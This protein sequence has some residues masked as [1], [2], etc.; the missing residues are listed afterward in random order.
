VYIKQQFT[1]SAHRMKNSGEQVS[2][3]IPPLAPGECEDFVNWLLADIAY[4]QPQ[5]KRGECIFRGKHIQRQGDLHLRGSDQTERIFTAATVMIASGRSQKEACVL[6]A[7]NPNLRLGLSR[8][9]RPA[10]KPE[11]RDLM[12]KAQTVRAILN[13][14]Q[15]HGPPGRMSELVWQFRW[16]RE[17]GIVEG[18]RYVPDSGRRMEEAWRRAMQRRGISPDQL[19]L[20]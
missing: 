19:L 4:R 20:G 18:S 5:D 16:L 17:N 8:R 2:G 11:P 1:F 6:I 15:F 13:T 9:G 14:F 10:K 3:G 7:N 12:S